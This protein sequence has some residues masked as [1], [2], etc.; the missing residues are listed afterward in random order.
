MWD[1]FLHVL[2]RTDIHQRCYGR[3]FLIAVTCRFC[4]KWGNY[5]KH[6]MSRKYDHTGATTSIYFLVRLWYLKWGVVS[7]VRG[8][9]GSDADCE[10]SIDAWSSQGRAKS[11]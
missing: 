4:D 11:P 1:L 8:R 9:S 5:Y 10:E 6:E 2:R 7:M 3:Q